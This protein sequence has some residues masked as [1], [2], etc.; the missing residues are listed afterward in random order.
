M[1]SVRRRALLVAKGDD[2][3]A[4]VVPVADC[5]PGEHGSMHRLAEA[6]VRI[7]EEEHGV[8]TLNVGESHVVPRE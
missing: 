1:N 5:S 3:E 6:A 4:W 8:A 2:D 7:P